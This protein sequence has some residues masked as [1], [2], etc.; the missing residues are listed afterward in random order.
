MSNPQHNM[1]SPN[2]KKPIILGS[3]TKG[4][5]KH[6]QKDGHWIVNPTKTNVFLCKCGNRYLKTRPGQAECVRCMFGHK[7]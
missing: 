7:K 6:F 2:Q 1:S 5:P 4:P 3:K